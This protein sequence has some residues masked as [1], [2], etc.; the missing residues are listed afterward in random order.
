VGAVCEDEER[1]V[2][3]VGVVMVGGLARRA[4]AG[5]CSFTSRRQR[6]RHPAEGLSPNLAARVLQRAPPP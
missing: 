3:G 1:D 6:V 2:W 5:D 4:A